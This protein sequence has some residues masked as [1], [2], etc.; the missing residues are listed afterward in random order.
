MLGKRRREAEFAG[1]RTKIR[2]AH[3]RPADRVLEL[4][5]TERVDL[6]R[7]KDRPQGSF[8]AQGV[9]SVSRTVV[10][11]AQCPVLVVA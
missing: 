6:S 10:E 8:T 11:R 4:R 1:I 7:R 9:G 5:D 3:G 2:L